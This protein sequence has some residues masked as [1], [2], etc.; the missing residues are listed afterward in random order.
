MDKTYSQCQVVYG[1]CVRPPIPDRWY[2]S[3]HEICGDRADECK[4]DYLNK[5]NKVA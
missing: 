2:T 4:N 1:K 5:K 3:G